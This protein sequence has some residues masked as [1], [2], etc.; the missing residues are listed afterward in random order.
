MIK[1]HTLLFI[2]VARKFWG[3]G[4]DSVAVTV[5]DTSEYKSI[6]IAKT[7]EFATLLPLP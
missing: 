6:E 3:R 4:F 2:S 1:W 5:I 7:I